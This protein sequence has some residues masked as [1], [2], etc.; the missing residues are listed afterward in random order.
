MEANSVRTGLGNPGNYLNF[1]IA[2]SRT[3]KSSKM[4][5]GGPGK[6]WIF[7]NSS[8]IVFLKDIEQSV[9]WEDPTT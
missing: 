7:V 6:S 9:G 2:F 8:N 5:V 1:G 4:V 3:G